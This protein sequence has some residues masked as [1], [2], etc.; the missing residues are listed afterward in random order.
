[1]TPDG[2]TRADAAVGQFLWVALHEVGHATF[3][4]FD[5]PIFG[6]AEDAADNFA[7]YIILQFGENQA[8]RLNRWSCVGLESLTLGDYKRNPVVPLTA[9]RPLRVT[10]ACPKSV[11]TICCAWPSA[12]NEQVFAD[13]EAYLPR[14]RSPHCVF[15][16]QRLVHAFNK[17]ILP[18]I[19]REMARKESRRYELAG[20]WN[21][22]RSLPNEE[23]LTT[24]FAIF[25]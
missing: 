23:N 1:M 14:T 8:R 6:S 7:T 15:E 3:V 4:M 2:I 12:P 17:T 24:S 22:N 9:R 5:V 16:Y 19:D 13:L 21:P 20:L 18:H 25:Q 10:T 11:T